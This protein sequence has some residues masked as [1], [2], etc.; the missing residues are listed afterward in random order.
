MFSRIKVVTYLILLGFITCG[1]YFYYNKNYNEKKIT[2]YGNVD[3]RDVV[4]GFR[5]FGKIR[6]LHFDEGDTR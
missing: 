6:E 4:L 1:S 3:I 5:V 2:I